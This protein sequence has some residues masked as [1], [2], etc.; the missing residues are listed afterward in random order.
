MRVGAG[1]HCRSVLGDQN[2]LV[3][4]ERSG[5][6]QLERDDV[7][8]CD[9][10]GPAAGD[11]LRQQQAGRASTDDEGATAGA[12]LKGLETVHRAGG[13]FGEYGCVRVQVVNREDLPLVSAHVLSEEARPVDAHALSVGAQAGTAGQAVFA[14]ATVHVRVDRHA[15]PAV[16]A[17]DIGADFVDFADHLV[18]GNQRVDPHIASVVEMQVG[19]ADADLVNPD[20]HVRRSDRC[21]GHIGDL[22]VAGRG[23]RHRAGRPV[24]R[25]RDVPRTGRLS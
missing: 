20:P 1:R 22:E 10:C 18:P 8:D 23:A 12:Q 5:R 14:F 2:G 17:G 19:A 6:L 24:R 4:A 25:D 9:R 3:N 11:E 16:E 21:C 15:L 7:G 13:R